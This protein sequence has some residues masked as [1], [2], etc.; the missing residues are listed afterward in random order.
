[1]LKLVYAA[2]NNTCHDFD[3]IRLN[4][5]QRIYTV[6]T[7]H[8]G[9]SLMIKQQKNVLLALNWKHPKLH[10]GV[11]TFAR[12]A[13]WHLNASI[14]YGGSIPRGW[15]G[16]G[17]ITHRGVPI[18]EEFLKDFSGTVVSVTPTTLGPSV[19][20]DRKATGRI[21]ARY[22]HSLG[23]RTM[24]YYCPHLSKKNDLR[25]QGFKE[26]CDALDCRMLNIRPPAKSLQW[27]AHC[28]QLVAQIKK[29]DLPAAVFAFEDIFAAE[30]LDAALSAG[31]RVPEDVSILGANNDELI[32][33]TLKV[34]LSSIEN[35]LIK[36]GYEAAALLDRLLDGEDAPSAPILIPPETEV[37]ARK[38]TDTYAIAHPGLLK[39]LDYIKEHFHLNIS[40]ADVAIAAAMSETSLRQLFNKNLGHTP[41]CEI[42]QRR[43]NLA[44]RLLEATDLKIDDI[45]E[46]S[47][48]GDRRNLHAAFRRKLE[49]TPSDYRKQSLSSPHSSF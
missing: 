39:A 8:V 26:E 11:A 9:N 2:S 43:L 27:S 1:L 4:H 31:L 18:I 29:A 28:D 12:E 30:I 41:T 22:F 32:C 14:E 20:N 25:R 23:F 45:A 10:L 36:V 16:S 24:L 44:C 40:V 5:A 42:L 15:T 38:S 34:S 47:G 49:T 37:I 7:Q 13:G 46:R 35:N 17:I 6:Q 19:S 33:E 48:F 3:I 21:A